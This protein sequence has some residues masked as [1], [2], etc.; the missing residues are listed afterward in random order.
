MILEVE[1]TRNIDIKNDGLIYD[2]NKRAWLT[3]IGPL[4]LMKDTRAHTHYKK[5]HENKFDEEGTHTKKKK[6]RKVAD[7]HG[8]NETRRGWRRRDE[9]DRDETRLA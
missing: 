6:E 4:I 3:M 1:L 5:I 9:V 8:L 7:L 2:I